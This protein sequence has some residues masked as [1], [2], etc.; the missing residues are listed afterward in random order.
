M[1]MVLWVTDGIAPAVTSGMHLTDESQFSKEPEGAVN[2][3]QPYIRV[4]LTH[5]SIYSSRSKMVL[6]RSDGADYRSSLW[7]K[8]IAVLPQCCDYFSL[9]KPH[10]KL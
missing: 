7:G 1:V 5:F 2:G 3:Y 4:R 9:C 6:S 8:F 10:L